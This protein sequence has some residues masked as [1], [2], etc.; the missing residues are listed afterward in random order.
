MYNNICEK[1]WFIKELTH[2]YLMNDKRQIKYWNLS[3]TLVLFSVL[4]NLN[5]NIHLFAHCTFWMLISKYLL[6]NC[7]IFGRHKMATICYFKHIFVLKMHNRNYLFINLFIPIYTII[8]KLS[9]QILTGYI[10][11]C[12]KLTFFIHTNT[13]RYLD[14]LISAFNYIPLLLWLVI[15][16]KKVNL[17]SFVNSCIKERKY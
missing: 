1:F 2:K 6:H 9:I 11:I 7:V 5:C 8:G 13:H 16:K 14:N 17:F 3:Q 10:Y 12:I 15:I 4:W